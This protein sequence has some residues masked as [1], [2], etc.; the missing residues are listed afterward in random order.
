MLLA[1]LANNPLAT[2]PVIYGISGETL[3][4]EEYQ[5]FQQNGCLGFILFARNIKNKNQVKQLTSQL[6]Q[7]LQG[8]PLILIDQ[9]G[10]RVS[11]LNSPE[12]PQF[13]SANYFA[14]LYQQ[15]QQLA[16]QA[17]KENFY[18]IGLNLK[19]LGINVNCAPVLDILTQ[20]THQIIGNRSFGENPQQVSDLAQSAC[21]GLLQANVL[22][23]IKHIPGHGRA[24]SDSH[25]ELPL[26]NASLSEL[27]TTDFL[28]FMALNKQKLAM[29]AHILYSQLDAQ[30]CG[31]V[32]S[33]VINII[34]KKIGF[35]NI[36]ITDDLSMKALQN[37]V[38]NNAISA[39]QAGCDVVLHCN[40]NMLEMQEINQVLPNIS[41]EL[42]HKLLT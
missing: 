8:D 13:P 24:T 25:L 40:G 26:V 5:F 22:P 27:Q 30:N 14:C 38:G 1:N 23:V 9:E 33:K 34:R 29:T 17:T 7:V 4:H 36:L 39:L 6:K 28:P 3:T 21:N 12:W 10:G 19:E 41:S 20:Y 42:K 15:N 18:Q 16:L 11:R 32:S 31:T 2:K 37:S 35:N